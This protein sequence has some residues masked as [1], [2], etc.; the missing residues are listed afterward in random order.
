MSN[1]S[2]GDITAQAENDLDWHIPERPQGQAM[3]AG[4]EGADER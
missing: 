3:C 1:L 4:A 2:G